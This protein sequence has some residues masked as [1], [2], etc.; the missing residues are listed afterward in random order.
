[1]SKRDR[2]ARGKG[3]QGVTRGERFAMIPLDVLES[4]AYC[5]LPDYAKV[6]L[7]ALAS[8]Y[9]GSNNGDLSLTAAVAKEVGVGQRWK[10][11]A[12]IKLLSQ[13]GLIEITRQGR[14]A[15]GGKLCTLF[16]LTW[17]DVSPTDKYDQPAKVARKASQDWAHWKAPANWREIISNV[18]RA[19][20]GASRNTFLRVTNPVTPQG[21]AVSAP[22]G[23]AE[24]APVEPMPRALLVQHDAPRTGV[25]S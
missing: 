13:C 17:R 19:S 18:R 3:R 12:G 11:N 4:E 22:T 6:V 23:G 21:G 5:R 1:M 25:T 15:H 8:R 7:V 14:L 20:K 10:R 9:T 16:A 2:R 24:S